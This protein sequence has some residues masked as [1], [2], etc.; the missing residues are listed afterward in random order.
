MGIVFV[1]LWAVYSYIELS[2]VERTDKIH[3]T[4]LFAA[5]IIAMILQS[6]NPTYKVIYIGGTFV[7]M[8]YYAFVIG[9]TENA[10][11]ILGDSIDFSALRS[12][13]RI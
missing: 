6:F 8:I 12:Y 1:I 10:V 4:E 2:Y 11:G 13:N 5:E 7:M 3:M 9:Q